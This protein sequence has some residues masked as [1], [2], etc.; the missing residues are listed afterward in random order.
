[1]EMLAK[2]RTF[3]LCLGVVLLIVAVGVVGPYLTLNPNKST[4]SRYEPP[5]SAHI[6]GCDVFGQDVLAQLVTGIRNSLMVGFL[7]GLIG[8]LIAF[9]VGGF[10]AYIGGLTDE[11]VNTFTN[12]FLILPV[13]PILIILSAS[14]K[15]RSLY[16]VAGFIGLI[17]W[18]GSARALRSQVLS[19]KE[20][21]F[22]NLA[23]ISGKGRTSIIFKEIFPNMLSYVFIS[24]CGM[25]GG[26]IMAEAGISLIGLGP[27]T[28]ATL[29]SMLYW[30]IQTQCIYIGV[31]WWFV[32][33]GIVLISF[34]GALLAIGSVIDDVLNPKLRGVV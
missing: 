7:A 31:W 30:S 8:L 9:A 11:T 14:L 23:R 18:A 27:T 3:Q 4:G 33:P 20:R 12:V 1:M 26:A 29:G 28:V 34:T 16:T 22:V 2:N 17:L 25:F 13:I 32:P 21:N 24:F 15:Q 19:L 6:L 5:S 10:S